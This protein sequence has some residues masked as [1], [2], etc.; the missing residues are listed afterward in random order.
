MKPM[1]GEAEGW[2]TFTIVR[3]FIEPCVNAGAPVWARGRAIM[4][5]RGHMKEKKLTSKISS[6]KLLVSLTLAVALLKSA[7]AGT[8]G[9]IAVQENLIVRGVLVCLNQSLK[10]VGCTGGGDALG[11]KSSDGR[12]Y[13]LKTDKSA[14]TLKEEKRLQTNE[15]QLTLRKTNNS[16]TY[17]IVKS[18]FI[19]GG[20]LFDFY[21][22]CDVCNITTYIPGPCMCCRQETEYHEKLVE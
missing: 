14:Q 17:E 10:Q 2:L 9:L 21:Y 6:S 4:F 11:L 22:Y 7:A 16:S 13:P 5:R 8:E 19:R 18:Q 12:I 1:Q 20:K 3:K 15:F